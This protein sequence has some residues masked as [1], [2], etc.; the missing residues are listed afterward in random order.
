MRKDGYFYKYGVRII[1]YADDFILMAHKIPG[2]CLEYLNS[3][4]N[5]MELTVNHDKTKLVRAT[6]EPFG[7]LGFTFKYDRDLHGRKYKYLNICPSKK[8][9]TNL[10]NKIKKHLRYNGHKNPKELSKRLKSNHTRMVQ[11]LLNTWSKLSKQ[12][13]TEYKILPYA[14]TKQV[15]SQKESAKM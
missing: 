11:L 9:E 5:R 8:S 10:R 15:L 12:V 13:E 14:K 2:H 4:L 3:M 7:F 1:R 6:Q